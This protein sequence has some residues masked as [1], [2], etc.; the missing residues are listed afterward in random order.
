MGVYL[1]ILK[2]SIGNIFIGIIVTMIAIVLMVLLIKG[3]Y[4]KSTMSIA[5]YAFVVLLFL[6]LSFQSV[7]ICGAI[8]IKSYGNKVEN[9]IDTTVSTLPTN[10]ILVQDES[11]QILETINT[12]YPLVGY[13]LNYTD[14]AGQT[15]QELARSMV[16]EM[17]SYINWYILRRVAWVLFFIVVGAVAIIKTMNKSNLERRSRVSSQQRRDSSSGGSRRHYRTSRR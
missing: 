11:Q 10:Q 17:R 2:Y 4:K 15:A 8:T 9:L 6:L 14:V 7:L 5:S 1:A 3:W 13:F 12:Q 16:V